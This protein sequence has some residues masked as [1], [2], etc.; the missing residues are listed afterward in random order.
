M[1][2]LPDEKKIMR[3]LRGILRKKMKGHSQAL[4]QNYGH[5]KEQLFRAGNLLTTLWAAN[6]T[7][8]ILLTIFVALPTGLL[9]VR[10][11]TFFLFL[12]VGVVAFFGACFKSV[13]SG[14]LTVARRFILGLTLLATGAATVLTGG[15]PSSVSAPSLMIPMVLSYCIYGGR[16][17]NYTAFAIA[18]FALGQWGASSVLGFTFPDIAST[19]NPNVNKALVLGATSALVCVAMVSFDISTKKYIRRSEMAVE[20]KANFLANMSHEIRTPMNGVVGLTDVMLKTKLD[21]KQET[22]MDAIRVSGN[23][24]LN[25]INDILDFSKIESGHVIVKQTEFNVPILLEEI[26]MLLKESAVKKNVRLH[27]EYDDVFPDLICADEGRLRQ[28]LTNLIGNAIKFTENGDVYIRLS[29]L[30][31]DGVD[32]LRVD[33]EDT[34]I[35]IPADRVKKVFDRFTQAESS[36]TKKFGGTGLGL[37]I[38][39]R[40]VELMDG[41]IGVESEENVGSIF[42][43]E[44]AIMVM[45]PK[46]FLKSDKKEP[47]RNILFLTHDPS[48]CVELADSFIRHGYAPHMYA[49]TPKALSFLAE[50]EFQTKW[51]HMVILD[52]ITNSVIAQNMLVEIRSQMQLS[53][54]KP[55]MISDIGRKPKADRNLNSTCEAR[56]A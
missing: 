15:Y 45:R 53:G 20:S 32:R 27:V 52:D 22:Y 34:G 37:T 26:L 3:R 12:L 49:P 7:I 29:L 47:P 33:I 54:V 41:E 55:V 36:T 30:N 28:I 35:G 1:I 4:K 44:I 50:S 2:R 9:D 11:K 51:H 13:L 23:A 39:Q 14:N 24:L 43:F 38:S 40:L 56:V 17:S 19:A 6:I 48:I 25:I 10:A 46:G 42:W 16:V 5:D 21:P 31:I 8:L 18:I